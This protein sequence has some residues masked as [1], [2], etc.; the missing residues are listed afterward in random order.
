[1]ATVEDSHHSSELRSSFIQPFKTLHRIHRLVRTI[2]DSHLVLFTHVMLRGIILLFNKVSKSLHE[3][4]HIL[5]QGITRG[6]KNNKRLTCSQT[7]VLLPSFSPACFCGLAW[8]TLITRPY[9]SAWSMLSIA[10]WASSARAN[11]T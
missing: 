2:R 3:R 6:A 4:D 11:S 1:M 8:L 7:A 5:I 9:S 10:S